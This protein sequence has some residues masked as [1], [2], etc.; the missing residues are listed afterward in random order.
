M[1]GQPAELS[2]FSSPEVSAG[3]QAG[4]TQ[5]VA[6]TR[7]DRQPSH[8]CHQLCP[9]AATRA[10]PCPARAAVGTVATATATPTA[11]APCS[12]ASPLAALFSGTAA[13]GED[14]ILVLAAVEG[15]V[16]RLP[17]TPSPLPPLALRTCRLPMSSGL[18]VRAS[19][20]LGGVRDMCRSRASLR[21]CGQ[22][23]AHG[24]VALE[25]N[26]GPGGAWQR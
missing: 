2:D 5:L 26:A 1:P 14:G 3:Q 24:W 25:R 6:L 9:P 12:A 18:R 19:T 7:N 22:G 10:R 4:A 20:P 8:R 17:L 21:R 15:E 23:A 16:G 11:A 13:K